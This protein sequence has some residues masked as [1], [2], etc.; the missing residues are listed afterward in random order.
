MNDKVI[1]YPAT[2]QDARDLWLWRNDDRTRAMSITGDKVSWSEHNQWF[3]ASLKNPNRYLF[4]G[5]L[6]ETREKIGLCRF[7][8]DTFENCAEVSINLNP[9]M[10]GKRLSHLLLSAGLQRFLSDNNQDIYA[11]VRNE[12]I[13]SI[14]CF[15]KCGF[16]LDSQDPE[17][18]Y[19]KLSRHSAPPGQ[20]S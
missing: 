11:T 10:R 8:V 14:K 19:Y 16:I 7:D 15:T 5:L 3:E 4:I 12:N 13:A 18:N 20:D 17:Y 2:A 9:A 6:V 1:I